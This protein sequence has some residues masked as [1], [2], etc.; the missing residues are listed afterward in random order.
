MSGAPAKTY[1]IIFNGYILY[2]V[3][4]SEAGISCKYH[5][6][7]AQFDYHG[8]NEPLLTIPKYKRILEGNNR[9]FS[10]EYLDKM[11]L[12]YPTPYDRGNALLV[13]LENGLYMLITDDVYLFEPGE[14]IVDFYS[15]LTDSDMTIPVMIGE[16]SVF[17]FYWGPHKFPK[18]AKTMDPIFHSYDTNLE[19]AEKIP[20]DII[21]DEEWSDHKMNVVGRIYNERGGFY[22]AMFMAPEE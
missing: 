17:C 11:N 22:S 5:S 2:D 6:Y 16:K 18:T 20:V 15:V 1:H 12:Y 19:E 3:I 21:I 7:G 13:E 4:V 14:E 10:Q 9:F 8:V